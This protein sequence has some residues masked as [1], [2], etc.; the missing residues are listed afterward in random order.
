MII[1]IVSR[2]QLLR[3]IS[4]N[5]LSIYICIYII[6]ICVSRILIIPQISQDKLSILLN[7]SKS[8]VS[9]TEM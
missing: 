7:G 4:Q 6:I 9:Q 3:Q 8:N 5:K 2:I 1:T